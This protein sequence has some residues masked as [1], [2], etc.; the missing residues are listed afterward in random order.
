MAIEQSKLR[1]KVI[2][3]PKMPKVLKFAYLKNYNRINFFALFKNSH[4]ENL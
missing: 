3:V 1:S 4:C 2:Y